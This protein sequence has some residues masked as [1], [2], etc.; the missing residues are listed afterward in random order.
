MC[1]CAHVWN[2]KYWDLKMFLLKLGSELQNL[3][4]NFQSALKI[5]TKCRLH[6]HEVEYFRKVECTFSPPPPQKKVG[7]FPKKISMM[8]SHFNKVGEELF[9][10]N[11]TFFSDIFNFFR[12]AIS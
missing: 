8:E 3:I 9:K 4:K 6:F 2:F 11:S 7:T 12:V 5:S 10:Q 1:A